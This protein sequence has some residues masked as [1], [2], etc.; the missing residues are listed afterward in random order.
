MITLDLR[1]QDTELT[2]TSLKELN[3][4]QNLEDK[5]IVSG[6][7]TFD[8]IKH[9]AH[10]LAEI[11]WTIGSL[12][13]VTLSEL[14]LVEVDFANS[15]NEIQEI[16]LYSIVEI[17]GLKDSSEVNIEERNEYTYLING[18]IYSLF[19][20]KNSLVIL[21]IDRHDRV[22]FNDEIEFTDKCSK[23]FTLT[24]S[25]ISGISLKLKEELLRKYDWKPEAENF[26]YIDLP[27]SHEYIQKNSI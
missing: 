13:I 4:F 12:N 20:I 11:L 8:N 26:Q 1:I 7:I 25:Q 15:S 27:K 22:I 23:Q 6:S 9:N 19:Y 24:D 14:L 2:I 18:F 10:S 3:D 17:E 5:R 21:N 16:I